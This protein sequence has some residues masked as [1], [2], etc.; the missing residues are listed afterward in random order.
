MKP[1][2]EIQGLQIIDP[3]ASRIVIAVTAGEPAGIGPDLCAMVVQHGLPMRI[4]VVADRELLQ[5]RARDLNLPLEI[6][7][8]HGF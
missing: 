6:F 7:A 5:Q 1:T 3:P 2:C 8:D 4:V